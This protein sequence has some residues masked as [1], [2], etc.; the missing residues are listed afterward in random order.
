MAFGVFCVAHNHE[1]R[2]TAL[3]R[4]EKW[5]HPSELLRDGAQGNTSLRW[6]AASML[7]RYTLLWIALLGKR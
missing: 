5:R 6:L 7:M 4:L 3:E 2:S 1:L